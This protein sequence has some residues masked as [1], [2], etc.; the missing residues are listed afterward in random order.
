MNK[1]VFICIF[2]CFNFTAFSQI[3]YEKGYYIN[4]TNEK[5]E[6]YI[7]NIDWLN[8]PTDF[9]FKSTEN[10]IFQ[11][12]DLASV[13]EFGIYDRSKYVREKVKI[14]RSSESQFLMS[15]EK[16]PIFKDEVIFLK[17]LLEGNASL[18]SY[19]DN[20]LHRFFFKT[21]DSQIEQLVYKN[22][23]IRNTLVGKNN[24]YK[25]Q[26]LNNLPCEK[27]RLT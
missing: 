15:S 6:G 8:N 14:D 22:Y 13:Q 25:Q 1:F 21:T 4:D 11:I 16:N 2:A 27:L 3:K 20:N 17:V 26:L 18:Y 10:S 9:S 19:T 7:K 12:L 24:Y 23:M 5:V